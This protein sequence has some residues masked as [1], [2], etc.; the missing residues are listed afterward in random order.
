MLLDLSIGQRLTL[1]FLAAA[2]IATLVASLVGVLRSQAL[3]RQSDFYQHLLQ[4]NTS[5]T[6][7]ANFLQLM[8]TA[9]HTHLDTADTTAPS[10]ESLDQQHK[11]IQDLDG[12][13][14]IILQ[15]YVKNDLLVRHPDQLAL[16]TEAGNTGQE[17]Q[18]QTLVGS[19]LRTWN[20]YRIAQNQVLQDVQSGNLA[21]AQKLT[22]VQAEP[23]CADAISALRALIQLNQ[24]LANSVHDAASVEEQYQLIT[25]IIGAILAFLAITL[26]GWFISNTLVKRLKQLRQVTHAV[27]QGQL[28]ERVHVVGRDEIADV[29]AS[30]NAMLEAI[31][32]LL[33]ETR[34]QRDALTNAAEHLFSDM[35]VVS[36]GDLRINAPVTDDPI[37]MLANAFNFTVSRFRRFVLRVQTAI[38]QIDVISRQEL[39][40]AEH[41]ALVLAAQQGKGGTGKLADETVGAKD[42]VESE[43]DVFELVAHLRQVRERLQKILI[44]SMQ[45]RTHTVQIL[46]EQVTR[47]LAETARLQNNRADGVVQIPVRELRTMDQLLQRMRMELQNVQQ[48]TAKHLIELDTALTSF[49]HS[50][51]KGKGRIVTGSQALSVKDQVDLARLSTSFATEVGTLA[52]KLGT[53]SQEMRAGIVAFQLDVPEHVGNVGPT[54]QAGI[55]PVAQVGTV[56]KKA[57]NYAL[58][59][60]ALAPEQRSSAASPWSL[61]TTRPLS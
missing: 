12:R 36:A 45:Q 10:Q 9:V 3:S 58:P 5:L 47:T 6:T 17:N 1:G 19:A 13:Y 14:D 25:T 2:L 8:N 55:G 30:V 54:S 52:R 21:N 37:G 34:N 27:E 42:N 44:E 59:N 15:E 50:L 48:N 33:Q 29:S 4:V 49:T 43:P 40:R 61:H 18:Q 39:E 56:S 23:T 22:R 35:R 31:V 24:R 38:E 28:Q 7:G 20:V 41:F 60:G 11:A 46:S 51:Q 57:A 16:L 26:V 53:L 32:N